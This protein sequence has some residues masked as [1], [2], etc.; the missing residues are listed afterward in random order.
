MR[1]DW[2]NFADI[3]AVRAEYAS[4]PQDLNEIA[5]GQWGMRGYGVICTGDRAHMR[6]VQAKRFADRFHGAPC[7]RGCY[8]EQYGGPPLP[9]IAERIV[10]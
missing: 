1:Q 10:A 2:L 6:K 9:S 7:P 3:A 8:G 5:P 4:G